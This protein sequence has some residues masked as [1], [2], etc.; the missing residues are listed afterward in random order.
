MMKHIELKNKTIL[1]S[2]HQAAQEFLK[3]HAANEAT[4]SDLATIKEVIKS[5]E[6]VAFWAIQGI[7]LN[8]ASPV[9]KFNKS[10]AL[11]LLKKLGATDADI[12][13]LTTKSATKRVSLL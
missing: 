11:L 3:V 4:K 7:A 12:N 5:H 9:S 13:G 2:T 6:D 10:A 8:N 1:R